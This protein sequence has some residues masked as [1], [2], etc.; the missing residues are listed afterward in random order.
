[1]LYYVRTFRFKDLL[2]FYFRT[3]A[4]QTPVVLLEKVMLEEFQIKCVS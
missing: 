4:N 2:K 1:M 3:V